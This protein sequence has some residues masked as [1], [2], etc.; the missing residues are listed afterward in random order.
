MYVLPTSPMNTL[1]GL[2]FQSRKP[3]IDPE[4]D[5]ADVAAISTTE[6]PARSPSRPSIKFIKLMIAVMSSKHQGKAH[7][8]IETFARVNKI[9][10]VRIWA[11][12][13]QTAGTCFRSSRRPTTASGRHSKGIQRPVPVEKME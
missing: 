9:N 7:K 1:A 12:Y 11:R 3:K 4:I 10:A 13:R 8:G 5:H 6:H 2:Q